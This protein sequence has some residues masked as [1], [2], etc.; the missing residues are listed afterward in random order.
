MTDVP[1][2]RAWLFHDPV[3]VEF[4]FCGSLEHAEERAQEIMDGHPEIPSI[5]I[6]E[7]LEVSRHEFTG[8]SG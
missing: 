3:E 8:D 1:K 5:E 2:Q 7:L 4:E 6:F